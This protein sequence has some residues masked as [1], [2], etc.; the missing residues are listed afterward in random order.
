MQISEIRAAIAAAASAVV[1]PTGVGKLTC[2]GYLPDSIYE[3]HFY[4]G[5]Y[6]QEYDRTYGGVDRVEFT[7]L[8]LVGRAD[9]LSCQKILDG[10]LSRGGPSSLKVAI[11]AVR[12][13][14]GQKALGGLAHD[15]RVIRVQAYRWYEHDG[16]KYVGAELVVEVIG[17]G[18]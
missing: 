4:V 9:D 18:A 17:D 10:L 1:M 3:P 6:D 13:A 14:P 11:E 15:L 8:V 7:C 16:T 2:T 12:G 5:E